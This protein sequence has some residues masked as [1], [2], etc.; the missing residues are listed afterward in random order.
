MPRVHPG[1]DAFN[2]P[3]YAVQSFSKKSFGPKTAE[4]VVRYYMSHPTSAAIESYAL[5][6]LHGRN[7]RKLEEHLLVCA[8]CRTRLSTEDEFINVVRHGLASETTAGSPRHSSQL[9]NILPFRTHL[10]LYSLEAAAG[11]FGK[12]QEVEPEGWVE[13]PSLHFPLTTD[14]YVTHIEGRSMQPKIPNGSLCA[15]RSKVSTPYG[16]KVLLM[17]KRP[18]D[19]VFPR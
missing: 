3:L 8:H 11:K 16:G 5:S 1:P 9:P 18:A 17:G 14:M 12:K 2:Q 6:R 19:T 7:L 15:F 13:V 10:P 4:L